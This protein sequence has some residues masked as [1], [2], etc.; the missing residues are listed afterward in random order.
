MIHES[1]MIDEFQKILK[2]LKIHEYQGVSKNS[3]QKFHRALFPLIIL[4]GVTTYV[5]MLS[6]TGFRDFVAST[7]QPDSLFCYGE[8]VHVRL[9]PTTCML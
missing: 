1:R 6:Y 9:E 7:M 4:L 8:M 5:A 2:S 3:Y